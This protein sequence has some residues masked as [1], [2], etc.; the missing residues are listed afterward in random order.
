M[1]RLCR[2]L[3][4]LAFLFRTVL[5][6]QFLHDKTSSIMKHSRNMNIEI[7]LTCSGK[8]VHTEIFCGLFISVILNGTWE[9]RCI[10]LWR[11]SA[12]NAWETKVSFPGETQVSI[13]W[14][15]LSQWCRI[16]SFWSLILKNSSLLCWRWL[17]QSVVSDRN[18]LSSFRRALWRY[19]ARTSRGYLVKATLKACV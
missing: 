10:T 2:Y 19:P 4:I 5:V 11:I 6:A 15:L 12:V 9:L 3:D 8:F 14:H 13:G 17:F 1:H 16:R 18:L 7:S